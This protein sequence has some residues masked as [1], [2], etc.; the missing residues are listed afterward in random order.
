[1]PLAFVLEPELKKTLAAMDTIILEPDHG[2][3]MLAWRSCLALRRNMFEVSAIVA[4]TMP[5]SWYAAR[6]LGKV[7]YPSLKEMLRARRTNGEAANR[8]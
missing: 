4:G 6:E 7:H 8:P 5:A 1:M 2:R 3:F